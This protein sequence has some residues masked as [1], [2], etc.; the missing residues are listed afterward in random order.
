MLILH[1]DFDNP[2]CQED[3]VNIITIDK[4]LMQIFSI[5]GMN[6]W[7]K[8]THAI[9]YPP[10]FHSNS[11]RCLTYSVNTIRS[12]G[13]GSIIMLQKVCVVSAINNRFV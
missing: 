13:P 5:Y 6:A 4:N 9:T 10:G 1:G 8:K 11:D 3:P 12:T 7:Y 2:V